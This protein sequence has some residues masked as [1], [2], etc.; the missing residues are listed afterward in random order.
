MQVWNQNVI[1]PTL[2]HGS[3]TYLVTTFTQCNGSLENATQ[4]NNVWAD[5]VYRAKAI[6]MLNSSHSADIKQRK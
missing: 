5:R 1:K 2:Q 4:L 6:R 3:R